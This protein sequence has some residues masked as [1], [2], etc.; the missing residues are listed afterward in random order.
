MIG[1]FIAERAI[2][3]EVHSFR[4]LPFILGGSVVSLL[5]NIAGQGDYI[6]GHDLLIPSKL[7]VDG[8][9]AGY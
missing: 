3:F 5:A 7:N 2:L 9:P 4:V 6:S 1:V 8:L